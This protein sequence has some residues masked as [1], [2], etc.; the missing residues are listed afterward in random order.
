MYRLT[1]PRLGQTMEEGRLD[2]WIVAPGE[3]FVVGD[4]LYEIETDKVTAG[5][6]A[7]LPGRLVRI[8][9]HEDSSIEVGTLLAVIA[10]PGEDP[11]EADIDAFIGTQGQTESSAPAISAPSA[12]D[13]PTVTADATPQHTAPEPAALQHTAREVTPPELTAPGTGPLRAMPRTRALARSLGV[14][15]ATVHGTGPEGL[16]LESD[17]TSAAAPPADEDILERRPLSAVHKQMARTLSRSWTEVPQFTQTIN[18]D[19]TGWKK[20]RDALQGNT[21]VRV[22]F[23]DLVLDAIVKAA[24]LVPEVNSRFTEDALILFREVS[25]ALAVDTPHGLLVPVLKDLASMSVTGRAR[26][27]ED[28]VDKAQ[29]GGLGFDD[30]TGGAITLSNLGGMGIESG[31]PL[32]VAPYTAIVFLG[33]VTERVVARE[34]AL[35]IRDMCTVSIAFDHRAVDGATAARFTAALGR[36]LGSN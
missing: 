21:G 33:A 8:L 35:A 11:S 22:T 6:E 7:T 32:L 13:A 16:I 17:V 26:H 31:T 25:V 28:L 20:T 34:G 15:I 14:D 3:S 24:T 27:R 5:V 10:S 29:S 2:H 30:M 23:T 4:E 1:L 9:T 18:V 36:A 12:S 19:V